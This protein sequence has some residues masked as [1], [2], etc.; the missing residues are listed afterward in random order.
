MLNRFRR[1][2]ATTVIACLALFFA[3]AGGSAIAL[4]GRNS[5]DSGDIKKGQVKNSDLANNAVTSKKI[6]NGQVKKAD[7]AAPEAF[8]RIGAPNE[9]PFGNGGQNDCVWSKFS[10]PGLDVFE[11]PGFYKDP[12]GRVYLTGALAAHDGPGGDAACDGDD[13]NDGLL[14]ILPPGYRPL[15]LDIVTAYQFTGGFD[16]VAQLLINGPTTINLGPGVILPAGAVIPIKVGG[17]DGDQALLDGLSF[18]AAGP[19][20]SARRGTIH[21]HGEAAALLHNL[22]GT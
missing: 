6:K 8:H 16:G 14:F 1:P 22:L 4:K 5:V 18:R 17:A 3:I 20:N 15:K 7:L 9:P 19:N 10:A 21:V 13:V 2:S 12:L 11:S